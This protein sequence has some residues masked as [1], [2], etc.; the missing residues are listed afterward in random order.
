MKYS[1]SSFINPP[2]EVEGSMREAKKSFYELAKSRIKY[3][4]S[5]D[6]RKYQESYNPAPNYHT[7][8][9]FVLCRSYD[10]NNE[11]IVTGKW[12]ENLEVIIDKGGFNSNGKDYSDMIPFAI[13]HEIYEAWMCA[14][15]GIG[16]DMDLH[17]RHLLAVRR[18]CRLAEKNG[19]GDRWLEFNSMKDPES[20]ELYRSTLEK[21]REN[22]SSF[23]E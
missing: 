2:H 19:L 17:D 22:P 11:G 1:E 8:A 5:E 16:H 23:E 20:S 18:E 15:K 13:E 14:K 3:L 6:F 21:I 9:S 4:N 10:K 7:H 12:I